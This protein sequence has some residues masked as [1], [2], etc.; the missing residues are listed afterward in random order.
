MPSAGARAALVAAAAVAS[1]M[2]GGGGGGVGAPLQPPLQPLMFVDVSVS[3][4]VVDRVSGR[5][6]APEWML[7]PLP[8]LV[9]SRRG[10]RAEEEV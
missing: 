1:Q 9:L 4:E 8:L 6:V 5:G 10:G 7:L 2:R 3:P